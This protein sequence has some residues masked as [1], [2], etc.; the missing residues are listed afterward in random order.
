MFCEKCG[1][2]VQGDH[3]PDCDTAM[4]RH[5][6]EEAAKKRQKLFNENVRIRKIRPLI[7]CTLLLVT[8]TNAMALFPVLECKNWDDSVFFY[9]V[10]TITTILSFAA[11]LLPPILLGCYNSSGDARNGWMLTVSAIAEA[12]LPCCAIATHAEYTRKYDFLR[13]CPYNYTDIC[14][15]WMLLACICVILIFIAKARIKPQEK[16]IKDHYSK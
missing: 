12:V 6:A 1:K 10:N 3:C 8:I 5:A 11:I 16:F 14:T 13:E 4:A 2:Y 15:V 9:S 7:L